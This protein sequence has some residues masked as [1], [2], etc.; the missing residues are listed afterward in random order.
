M[1]CKHKNKYFCEYEDINYI[2]CGIWFDIPFLRNIY[3]RTFCADC[4]KFIKQVEKYGKY[5]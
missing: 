2:L 4:G 1:S 3:I 5:D